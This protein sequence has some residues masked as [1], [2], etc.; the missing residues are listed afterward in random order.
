MGSFPER[1]NDPKPLLISTFTSTFILLLKNSYT[2]SSTSSCF[3]L[4]KGSLSIKGNNDFEKSGCLF[5][6]DMMPVGSS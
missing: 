3:L 2:D 1:L 4:T 5:I 6:K